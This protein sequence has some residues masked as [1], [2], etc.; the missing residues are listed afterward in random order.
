MQLFVHSR[1]SAAPLWIVSDGDTMVGPIRTELL[2]RG[3]QHGRVPTDCHVREVGSDEWR[4]LD[5]VREIAGLTGQTG[6]V[7][8]FELASN[9]LRRAHDEREVLLLLLH[10]AALATRAECGL[11]HRFRPPVGLPVTSYAFGNTEAALG[12]VLSPQDPAYLLA[13]TGQGLRGAPSRGL[14]ERLVAD[15]LLDPLLEGVVMVP[16]TFGT[17]LVAMLELGRYQREFRINDLDAL[18]RLSTL[19]IARLEDLL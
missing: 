3:V 17:E 7:N 11:V 14:A 8:D 9:E 16:V 13:K 4:R 18:S 10:G 15:R 1:P 2:L 12:S 6:S 5:Q 19:A